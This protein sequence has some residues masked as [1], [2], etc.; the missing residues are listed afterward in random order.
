ML[1]EVFPMAIGFLGSLH[2]VGMCGPLVLA[3]SLQ[4]KRAGDPVCSSSSPEIPK[5]S[6][7]PKSFP[8]GQGILMHLVFHFGRI[9]TYGILG[10][11]AAGLFHAV[12]VSSPLF[13]FRGK[14]ILVGGALL[15]FAGLVILKVLPLPASLIAFFTAQGSF[16]GRRIPRLLRSASVASRFVLGL[17]VGLIPCGLSWAMIVTAATTR[18]PVHGFLTMIAFGLGTLP[19]LLLT[20]LSA[21]FLSIK[22]RFMGERLAALSVIAMGLIMVFK[23]VKTL[24]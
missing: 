14:M 18:D 3:Y 8:W 17:S 12:D 7:P 9:L 1:S 15:I 23:G 4:M 20:G 6:S 22:A 19:A 10:A 11:L 13:N 5:G 21:S 24:G 2:C 16:V